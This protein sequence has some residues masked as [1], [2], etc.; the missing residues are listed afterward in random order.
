MS[1]GPRTFHRPIGYKRTVVAG[2]IATGV[3][4]VPMLNNFTPGSG[5]A[6]SDLAYNVNVF[7]ILQ[8]PRTIT[9]S[10]YSMASGVIRI[11]ASFAAGDSVNVI[12]MF[13]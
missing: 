13:V 6:T 1:T 4:Y 2:E 5:I 7:S 8:I 3:V 10:F 9:R 11:D 12:G